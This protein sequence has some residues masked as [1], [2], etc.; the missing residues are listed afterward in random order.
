M[1]RIFDRAGWALAGAL[2]LALM[3]VAARAIQA[4]SLDPTGPP[5]GTMKT[6][7]NIP[8]SWSRLLISNNGD[9]AGCNSSRLECVLTGNAGVLDHETGL[10]WERVPNER[11]RQARFANATETQKCDHPAA[12]I[13]HPLLEL[14][15]LHRA[16]VQ[17]RGIDRFAPVN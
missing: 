14:C 1:K 11:Q 2:G 17:R 3:L 6:L 7:S 8:G 4:G 9:G 13:E 12:I 16:S 15:Q 5:A 10:V